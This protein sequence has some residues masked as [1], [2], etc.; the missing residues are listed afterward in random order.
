MSCLSSSKDLSYKK[1][2]YWKDISLPTRGVVVVRITTLCKRQIVIWYVQYIGKGG[3]G[4]PASDRQN[5]KTKPFR[6]WRSE[7]LEKR[8]EWHKFVSAYIDRKGEEWGAGGFENCKASWYRACPSRRGIAALELIRSWKLYPMMSWMYSVH[9]HTCMYIC[10]PPMH[11]A[12]PSRKAL[13]I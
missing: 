5:F 13:P 1:L 7:L 11:H 2:H 4:P 6:F 9:A 10:I 12:S 8:K 3:V